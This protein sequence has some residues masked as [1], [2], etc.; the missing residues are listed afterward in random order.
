[1]KRLLVKG[2]PGMI[3]GPK[4]AL[5]TTIDVDLAISLATGTPF[6]GYFDVYQPVRVALISGESGEHTLQETARRICAAKGVSF[7][8]MNV[9]W[10]FDLPELAN[11]EHIAELCDGLIT[12]DIEVLILDPLYLCL[13]AGTAARNYDA[14]NLFQ[15]DAV[16]QVF[17]KHTR[18]GLH[19]VPVTPRPQTRSGRRADGVGPIG[20]RRLLRICP[21]VALTEPPRSLRSGFARHPQAMDDA[22][23]S[24]GQCGLWA[25]D[26]EEGQ[27][28]EDFTGRK[29]EV[30]IQVG[31]AARRAEKVEKINAKAEKERQRKAA[32]E[33]A[34]L[35]ALSQLAPHGEAVPYQRVHDHAGTS[36]PR[37]SAAFE[38]LIAG[39]IVERM[40]VEVT[41]GNGAN[42]QAAGVRRKPDEDGERL[43]EHA[44][45]ASGHMFQPHVPHEGNI[46]P[47]VPLSL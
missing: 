35:A 5:K 1:M 45:H 30:S 24:A 39:G 34:F 28:N 11:T 32:D 25:V 37:T 47:P 46:M 23:G 18:H 6:L 7:P 43:F 33:T 44:E 29:W 27:L 40:T 31:G 41:V 13:L 3:G 4:K 38:R 17:Q 21:A 19:A 10:H 36:R 16:P 8:D 20:L 42:R 2:Q 12:H 26:V 15:M 22:G 14:A 9:L